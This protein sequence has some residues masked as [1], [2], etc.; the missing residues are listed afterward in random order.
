MGR[1]RSGLVLAGAAVL[2][3]LVSA[4]GASAHY[5]NVHVNVKDQNGYRISLEASRS[6]G[7]VI[8]LESSKIEGPHPSAPVRALSRRHATEAAQAA[9]AK[10]SDAKPRTSSGFMSIQVQNHHAISNYGVHGTITRNRLFGRLGDFGRISLH[11]HVRHTRTEHHRC[12]RQQERL[13]IFKG[14]LRF[15]GEHGYVDVRAQR[16]HGKVEMARKH[17]HRCGPRFV[18]RGH[19]PRKVESQAR[20]GS[21][22]HHKADRYTFF[23]AHKHGD[24]GGTDFFAIKEAR[25][26]AAFLA[27]TFAFRDGVFVDRQEYGDGKAPDFRV[28]KGAKAARI[29]PSPH[30]FRGV[31]HFRGRHKA[32]HWK[33]SLVT[34][35]PGAPHLRLAGKN[36]KADL[37]Q[38]ANILIGVATGQSRS[39]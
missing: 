32:N 30:A 13:G 12:N 25:E 20:P 23:F 15:R 16:L 31:G 33:G 5:L 29:E 28:A 27:T 14:R 36:F 2:V 37:E 34:S 21:R 11:F 35:L 22:Q 9:N 19:H 3:A 6:T 18:S 4:S 26:D 7:R 39:R 1:V 24:S 8:H 10:V 17:L 38:S